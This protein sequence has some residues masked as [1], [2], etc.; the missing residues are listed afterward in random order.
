MNRISK[1]VLAVAALS[2]VG[3]AFAQAPPKNALE[4]KKLPAFTMK[5]LSGKTVNNA[6]LKGKVVIFDFWAT[7]CGPCMKASPLMQ[8]LHKKYGSKGLMVIGAKVQDDEGSAAD[9]AKKH[10]YTYK[11]TNGGDPLF[12]AFKVGGIPCFVFVDK[13]GVV[14][15]VQIGYGDELVTQF[16]T[17]VKTLLAAK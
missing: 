11:F 8:S 10:G 17:R 14:N 13:K 2:V 3:S 1:V 5:D 16:E 7:W 12:N 15:K 6:S 4:G 9:Y